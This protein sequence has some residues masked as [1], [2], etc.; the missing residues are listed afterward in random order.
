MFQNDGRVFV[1]RRQHERFHQDCSAPTLKFGGGEMMMWVAML[2]KGTGI[3]KS[4]S[5]IRC[6]RIHQNLLG[7]GD[8]FWYQDDGA[9]CHRAKRVNAWKEGNGFRC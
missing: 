9:P 3:L 5:N 6:Q 7:Y 2:Y 1:R 4:V 8:V